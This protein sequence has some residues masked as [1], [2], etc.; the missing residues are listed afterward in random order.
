MMETTVSEGTARRTF[1]DPAGQAFLPN[2]RVAGKTGTL[3]SER[4]YRGYT[5]FV[6]FAPA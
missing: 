2:V 1:R 5:W 6:G 3:S 4:P